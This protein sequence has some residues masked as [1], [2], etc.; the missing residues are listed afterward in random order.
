[1]K[2]SVGW[3]AEHLDVRVRL[4][5]EGGRGTVVGVGV[6]RLL[7]RGDKLG[8]VFGRWAARKPGFDRAQD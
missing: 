4:W 1:M 5:V 3:D 2:K 7:Y 6:C 8:L